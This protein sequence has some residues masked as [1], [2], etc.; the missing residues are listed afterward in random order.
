[1]VTEISII[2]AALALAAGAVASGLGVIPRDRTWA[3]V[4]IVVR[5]IGVVAL[6]VALM[7]RVVILGQ[8]SPYDQT[9][10][11]LG[12]V[13]AML[14]V[15]SALAWILKIESTGPLVEVAGLGL[16]LAGAARVPAGAPP[17]DC[18]QRMA[19]FQIQWALFL[20]GGGSL[21]VAGCV[22]LT[23]VL[24]KA[25]QS[26]GRHL[27]VAASAELYAFLVQ[28][29]GLALVILGSGLAVSLWWAWQ[30]LGTLSSRDPR[31]EWMVLTWLLTAMS[32]LA[33]QLGRHRRR[34]MVGLAV[35][36]ASN[37]LFGWLF[38]LGVQGLFAI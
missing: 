13:L 28:A 16:L 30:T 8:W 3:R 25:V 6:T 2:I 19:P 14:I 33:G 24:D 5:A 38:L 32:L 31:T 17:L 1:M 37:T 9:L 23:M 4:L 21:L 34:W 29:A 36:A 20:L 15:H 12:L 10:S 26:R 11:L 27:P 7:G 35:L 18:S 22:A